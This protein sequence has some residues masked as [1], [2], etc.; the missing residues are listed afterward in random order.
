[1]EKKRFKL[2]RGVAAILVALL[3]LV[4]FALISQVWVGIIIASLA[5]LLIWKV[6]YRIA[7]GV[8]LALLVICPFLLAV[9]LATSANAIADWAF[10]ILA[11][12]VVMQF[13]DYLRSSR[14]SESP[15]NQLPPQGRS[16]RRGSGVS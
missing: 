5:A 6:D 10:Y 4:T 15:E 11:V 3:V 7:M 13:I 16:G 8:S 14:S 1:M 9:N 12:A 2:R